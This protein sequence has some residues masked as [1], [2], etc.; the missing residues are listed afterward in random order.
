MIKNINSVIYGSLIILFSVYFYNF[1]INY[2]DL[3]TEHRL[4]FES[5]FYDWDIASSNEERIQI[6]SNFDSEIQN[7]R[8]RLNDSSNSSNETLD[9]MDSTLKD[10]ENVVS[11]ICV[12]YTFDT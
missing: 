3:L 10:Y 6:Q 11:N 4:V 2:Y 9:L 1:A 8:D 5:F 12:Q 7:I